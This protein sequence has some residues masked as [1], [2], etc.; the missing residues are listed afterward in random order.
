MSDLAQLGKIAGIGGIAIGA[1][2]LILRAVLPGLGKI[3]T[4]A[5][6]AAYN[7][8]IVGAFGI[9]ALGI[10]AWMVGNQPAP[11]GQGPTTSGTKS[12][13]ISGAGATVNYTQP[14]PPIPAR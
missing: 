11:P 14:P 3:P 2:V 10:I 4:K 1:L 8:I 13:A 12:P 5:R 7:K 9:A 6:A